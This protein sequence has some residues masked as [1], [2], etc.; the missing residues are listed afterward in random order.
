MKLVIDGKN[1]GRIAG[2]HQNDSRTEWRFTMENGIYISVPFDKI[3]LFTS[4]GNAEIITK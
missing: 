3:K 2:Y 4:H 1:Y